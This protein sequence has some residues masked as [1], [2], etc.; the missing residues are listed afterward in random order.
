V[1]AHRFEFDPM[2]LRTG[3]IDKGFTQQQ[4]ADRVP[5]SKS[6]WSLTELG[7]TRPAAETLAAM[8]EVVDVSLDDLFIEID[9][10]AVPA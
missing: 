7:Y 3:R 5:C 8:A 6:L 10:N 2:P 4:S 1:P 9:D